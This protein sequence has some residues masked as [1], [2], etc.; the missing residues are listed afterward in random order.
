MLVKNAMSKG[1]PGFSSQFWAL[2]LVT[3]PLW[4]SSIKMVVLTAQSRYE[5]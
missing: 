3:E 5:A 1:L 2:E 4:A